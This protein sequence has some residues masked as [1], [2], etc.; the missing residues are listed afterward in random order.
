M[1][2]WRFLSS[3]NFI[4]SMRYCSCTE[5]YG[6][7]LLNERWMRVTFF[8]VPALNFGYYECRAAW[9]FYLGWFRVDVYKQEH[10]KERN[11][12]HGRYQSER[13]TSV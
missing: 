5:C 13:V 2:L 12:C 9:V 11:W 10:Q 8:P 4:Q 7:I 3:W 1:K 6:R